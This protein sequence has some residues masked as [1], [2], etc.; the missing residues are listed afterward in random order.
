MPLV[1]PCQGGE[2]PNVEALLGVGAD[3]NLE[4]ESGMLPPVTLLATS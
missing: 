2:F 1:A 3:P 4:A